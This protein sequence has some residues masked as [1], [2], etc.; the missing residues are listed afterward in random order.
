M[1]GWFA[2]TLLLVLAGVATLTLI[3]A[4]AAIPSQVPGSEGAIAP[5]DETPVPGPSD[6]TATVARITGAPPA[7]A[8]DRGRWLESIGYAL[9]ALATFAGAGLILLMRIAGHLEDIARD[10]RR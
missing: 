1:S 8:P 7:S 9:I 4:I 6:D 2:R 5:R 10:R 3:G